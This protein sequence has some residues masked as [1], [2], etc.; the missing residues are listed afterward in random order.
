MALLP[1]AIVV[2]IVL[3]FVYS[4]ITAETIAGLCIA[5]AT[6]FVLRYINNSLQLIRVRSWAVSSLYILLIAVYAPMHRWDPVEMACY[7]L[8]LIFVIGLL[9]SYQ[10]R[11]PQVGTFIAMLAMALLTMRTP[12]LVCLVPMAVIAMFAALRTLNAKTFLAILFGFMLPYEV[13]FCWHLYEGNLGESAQAIYDA[14]HSFSLPTMA[15][16]GS[17]FDVIIKTLLSLPTLLVLLLGVF[18]FFS[19]VHFLNTSYNDKIRTR[20]H[21]ITLILQWPVLLLLLIFTKG[22][23]PQLIGI[24]LICSSPLLAHYFVLSKGWVANIFFWIFLLSCSYLA[25]Q[26]L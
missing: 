21:Y 20:M 11:R 1:V 14:F 4:P 23:E 13:W 19:I 2:A 12:Q 26:P 10:V 5:L 7:C 8:Y 25:L 16:G 15:E 24:F 6:T 22:S 18:G 3:W 9:Y 17:F